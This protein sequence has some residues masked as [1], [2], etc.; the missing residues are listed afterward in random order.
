MAQC[1]DFHVP[2]LGWPGPRECMEEE[3]LQRSVITP[4]KRGA[5]DAEGKAV[6]SE[7]IQK[8]KKSRRGRKARGQVLYEEQ[9]EALCKASVCICAH[10]CMS[11][12]A[13][14]LA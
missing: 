11:E 4:C 7:K 14:V 13:C 8:K 12:C 6:E 3:A 1:G 5:R 2:A 10:V 9:K